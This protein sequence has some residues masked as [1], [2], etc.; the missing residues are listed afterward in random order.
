MAIIGATVLADALAKH[1][2]DFATAFADYDTTLRPYIDEVQADAIN[3]GLQMF[4][5]WTADDIHSRD[6]Q[7]AAFS[8]L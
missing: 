7:L 3:F 4:F 2:G 1:S 6:K 5:P 8:A